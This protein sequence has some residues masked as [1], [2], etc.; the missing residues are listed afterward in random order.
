VFGLLPIE[1]ET[2]NGKLVSARRKS[3]LPAKNNWC[4][5][6]WMPLLKSSIRPKDC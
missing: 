5:P 3:I 4:A 2:E 1:A 6:S